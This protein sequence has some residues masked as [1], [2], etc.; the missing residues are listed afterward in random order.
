MFI[1]YI[2][3]L[4]MKKEISV[5]ILLSPKI[6]DKWCLLPANTYFYVNWNTMSG[7]FSMHNL[8]QEGINKAQQKNPFQIPIFPGNQI[9]ISIWLH[10]TV[11]CLLWSFQGKEGKNK[12][13][14]GN[15]RK[16]EAPSP[17]ETMVLS[18]LT[19]TLPS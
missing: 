2:L 4:G 9:F 11:N 15:T 14:E 6:L 7:H 10:F 12:W 3:H 5:F 8:H 13:R 17:A 16:G 19:P 18:P 1:K